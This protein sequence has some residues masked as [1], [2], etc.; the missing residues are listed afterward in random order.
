MDL[1][2]DQPQLFFTS[3]RT[4]CAAAL[5]FH[6]TPMQPHPQP[7]PHEMPATVHLKQERIRT[8]PVLMRSCLKLWLHD[9][10]LQACR[11]VR[12]SLGPSH[13]PSSQCRR[14]GGGNRGCLP[15]APSVRGSQ[16]VL[17]TFKYTSYLGKTYG[18]L[19]S[20]EMCIEV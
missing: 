8:S 13:S 3:L 18:A 12:S 19:T 4:C 11:E 17:N 6:F 15:R 9:R 1:L 14:Q 2:F 7:S 16:T 5:Q 20:S 10:S